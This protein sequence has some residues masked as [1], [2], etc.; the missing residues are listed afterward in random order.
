[1]GGIRK[2]RSKRAAKEPPGTFKNHENT[3]QNR[4]LR[5]SVLVVKNA[6]FCHS[7]EENIAKLAILGGKFFPELYAAKYLLFPKFL[8]L[9][10]RKKA[11]L[12]RAFL[13]QAR[14]NIARQFVLYRPCENKN[15]AR[16]F[17]PLFWLGRA[18]KKYSTSAS[19]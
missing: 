8:H 12:R 16:Q 15:I 18:K 2:H 5:K 17:L 1:M 6:T 10:F 7:D 9:E 13:P 4:L 3:I 14:K 19:E 11:R